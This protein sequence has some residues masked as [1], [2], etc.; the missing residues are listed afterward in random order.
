MEVV[1]RDLELRIRS[2]T[3][4]RYANIAVGFGN[5]LWI[6][7]LS[8]SGKSLFAKAMTGILPQGMT[9]Q[10]S[11][12]VTHRALGSMGRSYGLR[13][14]Y[15]PQSPASALPSAIDCQHLLDR[16]AAWSESAPSRIDW[17]DVLISLRLDP[18]KLRHMQAHQLSGGMAQRFAI[19]LGVAARPE[20]LIIDE[21]TVG[22]D[23]ESSASLLETLELPELR[24]L[25]L[26][27]VSHDPVIEHLCS[28]RIDLVRH[29]TDVRFELSD[30]RN[31]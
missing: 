1:S 2:R 9:Q 26:V 31:G 11:V 6:T 7:G 19:A 24:G 25:P 30:F 27:I 8:G 22:L 20:L 29:G 16:V 18:E 15:L 14:I 21:P 5:R 3:V 13:T 10:G 23:P 17:R 28:T 12:A 4:L